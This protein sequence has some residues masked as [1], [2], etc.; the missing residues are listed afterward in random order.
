MLCSTEYVISFHSMPLLYLNLFVCAS[1]HIFYL[2]PPR[3]MAEHI[4]RQR[5]GIIRLR[6]MNSMRNIILSCFGGAK[7]NLLLLLHMS[8]ML[9]N[10]LWMQVC[11][12][13]TAELL[14]VTLFLSLSLSLSQVFS[15]ILNLYVSDILALT[16]LNT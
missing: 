9:S 10:F 13:K 15:H 1:S 16:K 12:G 5:Y 3:E 14:K 6:T 11:M 4:V 2:N 8:L 7:H